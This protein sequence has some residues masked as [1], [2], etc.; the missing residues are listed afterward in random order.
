MCVLG[1]WS[2]GMDVPHFA[3][4]FRTAHLMSNILT[5][6]YGRVDVVTCEPGSEAAQRSGVVLHNGANL[7]GRVVLVDG[8][9]F[10]GHPGAEVE[11][12]DAAGNSTLQQFNSQRGA[13]RV[14]IAI[15]CP[16]EQAAFVGNIEDFVEAVSKSDT[17]DFRRRLNGWLNDLEP[18]LPLVCEFVAE[19]NSGVTLHTDL[20]VLEAG[21]RG[22]ALLVSS[23]WTAESFLSVARRLTTPP[24][25][26]RV[27]R[28]EWRDLLS[29]L[30]IG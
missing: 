3:R 17:A 16:I 4:K 20:E 21:W 23:T 22:H 18:C 30:G 8:D 24:R 11:L 27:E 10:L 13:I 14:R 2:W 5:L 26:M 19:S 6:S 7:S 12:F 9:M 29:M 1:S 28:G 25:A 15:A